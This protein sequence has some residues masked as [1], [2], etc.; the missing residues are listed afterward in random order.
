MPNV[1][2]SEMK[3]L[4]LQVNGAY[5]VD[6]NDDAL[7]A[8]AFE[9]ACGKLKESGVVGFLATIITD[10]IANRRSKST[11]GAGIGSYSWSSRLFHPF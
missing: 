2:S 8:E 3:Y 5:G 7:T 6:F 4:D 10:S 9:F 1:S 11:L